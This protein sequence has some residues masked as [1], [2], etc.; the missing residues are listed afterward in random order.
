MKKILV[1]DNQPVLLKLMSD[2]LKRQGH[3]VISA[4][5]GLSAL[6]V[7]KTFIPDVIFVDLVMPNISGDK[8]CRI[9]RSNPKFNDV[10]IVIISAIA[11]EEKINITEIDADACIA[12][13]PFDKMSEHVLGVLEQLD[14]KTLNDLSEKVIGIEN[15]YAREITKE[16]LSSKR[17]SEVILDNM[18]EGILELNFE[19]K[20]IFANLAV[21]LLSGTPETHLL[22]SKF[23][24]LFDDSHRQRIENLIN[25]VD[26][27]PQ[28]TPEDSPVTLNGKQVSVNLLPVK[29]T[30]STSIIAIMNDISERKRLEFQ[31][32]QA[33]KM[34]SI[35]TFAGGIAHNLNNI[36]SPIMAHSEMVMMDLASDSP[37]Q[38]NMKAI[39]RSGERARDAVK[40]IIAFARQKES[41]KIVIRMG[42]V[43][44]EAI[45]L[46]RSSIPTTIDIHQKLEV[47]SDTVFADP[48]QI[49]QVIFNLCTNASHA[50]R[51]KGGVLEIEL[52][53]LDLNS[54]AVIQFDGL[55]PGSFIRLTVKDTGHGIAPGAI[56]RIFDPYYST[57]EVNEGTGMGLSIAHGIVKSHGGDITVES[58]LGK[59]TTFQVLFPRY[60]E[61]I[62]RVAAQPVHP[63]RKTERILF[64]DDERTVANVMQLMLEKLGY[65]V[66]ARTSS[67]E[68]LEAFRN[69][70]HGFDLVITDMTMPHMTGKDLAK[71][72]MGIRSDIPIILCTG[73]SEQIDEQKAMAMGIRAYVMKPIEMAEIARTIREVLDNRQGFDQKLL[74]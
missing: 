36:L 27:G 20:I 57:K 22:A 56:N 48:T 23:S 68:A 74:S 6:D 4:K 52:D 9:I 40:Q 64:V 8:L 19:G 30:E 41:E 43:I 49:H 35:G 15:V 21:T 73:F 63:T 28:K 71:E 42:F 17:H 45:K 58:G 14:K 29:N 54:E 33:H 25:Q 16:L 47:E 67:I 3:Q 65:K 62:P 46:L 59:G 61:D 32:Q 26:M 7:L 10:Y 34:D 38:E 50:M 69:N 13:G 2:L 11:A 44:K 72:I 39:F 66:S 55:I 37:L 12:K 60:E 18:A 53:E 5:D 51:E 31:L 24:E 1:I 70:P